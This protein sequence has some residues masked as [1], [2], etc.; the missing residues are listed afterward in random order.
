LLQRQFYLP[1]GTDRHSQVVMPFSLRHEF[2]HSL[3]ET[4]GNTSTSHLGI[5]KTLDHVRQRAHWV[6]WRTD[7]GRYCRRYAVC[8]TVQH[9]NAPCHGELQSYEANGIGDRLHVDLTGSHPPSRQGTIYILTAIDAFSRYLICVPLQ[10]KTAITVATALVEHVFLPHGCCRTMVSDQG[11]E[12]C[13]EVLEAATSNLGIRKLRTTAYRPSANGRVERVHRTINN[14]FS[15]IISENQKDWQDKLPMVT[16]AYNT[17]KHEA[18][19]YSPFY[20]VYGRE[21]RTPLD[22][23]MST[24]NVSCGETVIDY[25]E[26]LHNR[27]KEAYTTVNQKLKTVTDRMK[28]RYD[29]KMNAVQ[30]EPD[31]LVLYYCTQRRVEKNFKNGEGL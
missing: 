4:D 22:L 9:G 17:A 8:Q 19:G 31:E 2:S 27:L 16:A 20:L 7:T 12:F 13:N 3:N 1:D 30:L 29:S 23:I 21:Y 28:T 6:N 18:T 26:Q 25:V 11:R 5:K 24:A 15:K 14:L 10:N